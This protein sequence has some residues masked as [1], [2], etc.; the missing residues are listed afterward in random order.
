MS[1]LDRVV[2]YFSLPPALPPSPVSIPNVGRAHLAQLFA[3]LGYTT[4]AEIGVWE[5]EYSEQLCQQNPGLHLLCVDA[6]T[7][8]GGDETQANVNDP[9]FI[10]K[11]NAARTAA[12]ARLRPY[13]CS[14]LPYFSVE[15]AHLVPDRSLDFVYIDANHTFEGLVADFASW[16]PKV[17]TGGIIAGHDYHQFRRFRG[18]RV[19]EAV[20]G[21]TSAH[22]IHPWFLLGRR[23]RPAGEYYD[24]IRSFFWVNP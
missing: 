19:I 8:Y 15:A 24:G 13:N 17:R 20:H 18:V 16:V 6:W 9:T 12:Y 14:I 21:Y 2:E 11:V 23:K 5:G 7:P 4:G 1:T 3:V 10:A 22:D